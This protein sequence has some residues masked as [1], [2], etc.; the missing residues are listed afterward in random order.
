[1]A[2]PHCLEK[3]RKSSYNDSKGNYHYSRERYSSKNYKGKKADAGKQSH[4]R[5]ETLRHS[6][7]FER[8]SSLIWQAF[9]SFTYLAFLKSK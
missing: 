1:M 9:I 3:K 7:R 4:H 6:P 5:F 8:K 2:F